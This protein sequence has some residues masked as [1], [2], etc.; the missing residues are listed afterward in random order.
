MKEAIDRCL[1]EM[2]QKSQPKGSYLDYVKQYQ[3]GKLGKDDRVFERHFLC[4]NQFKYILNK[5][6]KAYGFENQWRSN[7]DF[8]VQNFKEGGLR[9]IWVEDK[10]GTGHREAEHMKP[11]KDIIGEEN[12]DKLFKY[13]EDVKDFYRFDRKEEQFSVAVCLGVSPTSNPNT[14]REYW[15]SQGKHINIDETELSEDDYWEIDEYGHILED[16]E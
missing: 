11:I 6:K 13:I 1:E 5:Y 16:D 14:V 4:H 3:E 8:L 10:N 2:Y 12:A 15:A 7:V 9:D